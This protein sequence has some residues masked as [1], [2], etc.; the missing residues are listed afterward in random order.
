MQDVVQDRTG[1]IKLAYEALARDVVSLFEHHAS[2]QLATRVPISGRIDDKQLDTSQQILG[3]LRNAFVN[4]YAPNL[5]HLQP[6]DEAARHRSANRR[7]WMYPA[8]SVIPHAW[9]R[10]GNSSLARDHPCCR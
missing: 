6:V 8:R 7:D 2:D 10:N 4:A 1:P 5:K 3:V 9:C